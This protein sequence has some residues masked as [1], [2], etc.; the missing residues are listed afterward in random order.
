VEFI[1]NK[2]NWKKEITTNHLEKQL[3]V[4]QTVRNHQF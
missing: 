1:K 2:P 4:I 3:Y